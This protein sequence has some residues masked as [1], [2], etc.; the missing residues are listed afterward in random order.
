M[1]LCYVEKFYFS[2]VTFLT[3]WNKDYSLTCKVTIL[4]QEPLLR[5]S[6]LTGRRTRQA[7]GQYF[8][9]SAERALPKPGTPPGMSPVISNPL[10]LVGLLLQGN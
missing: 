6:C 3:C 1:F 9:S 2:V 7:P 4:G 10:S 8:V 5:H